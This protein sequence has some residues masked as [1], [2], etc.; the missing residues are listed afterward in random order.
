MKK[1]E[2]NDNTKW[3]TYDLPDVVFFQEGPGVRKWQFC[4]KGVKLLNGSNINVKKINLSNTSIYI[5]EE[6]AYG[7]YSHF[8]IDAGDLVIASSGIVVDNFHNKIAFIENEHLPLCMNTSTIRFK[9]LDSQI[10][11]LKYLRFFLGTNAFKSQLQRL[12]TGSAQLNFGPSHLRQI[13]IPLPPLQDQIRIAHLL[14]KVEGLIARRKEDMAQLDALLKSVF[15]DMFGDPVRNEKG[16][17]KKKCIEICE[18]L[19]GFAFKSDDYTE[20]Q[21]AERLCSG[22]IVMPGYIDWSKCIYWK[23]SINADLSKYRLVRS[24]IV[25]AMDRPWISSGLKISL[26]SDN[27]NGSF[28]V[29]RTA[30]IRAFSA[31]Q[32]FVYYNLNSERFKSHCKPTETTIPHISIKE[33]ESFPIIMPSLPLQNKFAAIVE[34]VEILKAQYQQ[35]LTDLESLY[36]ALSQKAFAGDLDLE[37]VKV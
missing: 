1:S 11:T 21:D 15:L 2:E 28:L 35:S 12:I 19:S 5:S 22:L 8:L 33:I 26:I 25:L 14:E 16:W 17:E 36:G 29:Q 18:I 13:K 9:A 6:E 30:R 31:N 32:L 7:K 34:K 10:L 4:D 23:S 3:K 27:G 24:D 37:R 20:D